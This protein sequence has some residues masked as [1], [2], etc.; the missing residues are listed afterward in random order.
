ME[1]TEELPE[2]SQKSICAPRIAINLGDDLRAQ[3]ALCRFVY[4]PPRA[5]YNRVFPK[6]SGAIRQSQSRKDD[7]IAASRTVGVRRAARRERK[8]APAKL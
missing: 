5:K 6:V 8:P 3:G 1:R 7:Q 2:S 4:F